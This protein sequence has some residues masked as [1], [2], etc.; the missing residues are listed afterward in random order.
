MMN[1]KERRAERVPGHGRKQRDGSI[2]SPSSFPAFPSAPAAFHPP[3]F[4]GD[5]APDRC[6]PGEGDIS[7]GT[8]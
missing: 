7:P 8:S 3:R 5:A 4:G 1:K 6:L 2:P